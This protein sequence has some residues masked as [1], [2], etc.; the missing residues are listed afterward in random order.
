M[1]YLFRPF[2]CF[3]AV[4]AYKVRGETLNRVDDHQR[5][6]LADSD[7]PQPSAAAPAAAHRGESAPHFAY[8][9]AGV[10]ALEPGV[11]ARAPSFWPQ[12]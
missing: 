4:A 9:V 3:L 6:R 5:G 12:V 1:V 7:H 11:L 10:L 2:A 8:I